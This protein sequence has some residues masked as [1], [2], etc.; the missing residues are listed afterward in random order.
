[1]HNTLKQ[2]DST[3]QSSLFQMC[4]GKEL[5]IICTSSVEEYIPARPDS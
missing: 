2:W 4:G 3:D 1:M 5:S